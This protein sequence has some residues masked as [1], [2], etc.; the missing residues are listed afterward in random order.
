[1]AKEL[2]VELGRLRELATNFDKAAQG[3]GSI[4]TDTR[5][6]EVAAALDNSA[7]S[8]ACHAGAQLAQTGLKAV[9]AHYRT[10][11]SGT[12][13]SA[14]AYQAHDNDYS[15]RLEALRKSL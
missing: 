6:P 8:S 9:V 14:D 15:Q 4:T 12:H 5:T 2:H 13:T 3:V 1:M 7:T 10:L 11:H